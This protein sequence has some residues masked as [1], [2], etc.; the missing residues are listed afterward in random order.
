MMDELLV[1]DNSNLD[2]D[3]PLW[4]KHFVWSLDAESRP[5]LKGTNEEIRKKLVALLNKHLT[6]HRAQITVDTYGRGMKMWIRFDHK[7][8]FLKFLLR[9]S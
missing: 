7:H 6:K 3:E 2:F 5:L 8:D 9:Y 1:W 4:F